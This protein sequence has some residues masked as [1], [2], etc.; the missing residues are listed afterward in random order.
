[1]RYFQNLPGYSSFKIVKIQTKISIGSLAQSESPSEY[2]VR[3][4]TS[5]QTKAYIR[6]R[7]VEV[8][9]NYKLTGIIYHIKIS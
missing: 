2:Y 6:N 8:Y 1:M 9:L 5:R 7:N 3:T 4:V